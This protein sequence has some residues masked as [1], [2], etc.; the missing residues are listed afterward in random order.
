MASLWA[1]IPTELRLPCTDEKVRMG[2]WGVD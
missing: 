2:L 1:A